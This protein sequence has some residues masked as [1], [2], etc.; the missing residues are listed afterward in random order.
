MN[1]YLALTLGLACAGLGGELFVRGAVGL[2]RL[3]RIPAGIVGATVAAFA[4]SS[5]ELSVSVT[6]ALAG[7]PQIA[8]GDALGSNV[9]NTALILGLALA[10]SGLQSQRSNLWR[11]FPVAT[12]A[13]AATAV[14]LLDGVLSRLDGALMLA[15][16]L[17][18]LG[19]AVL[20]AIRHR[21]RATQAAVGERTWPT[22]LYG[23]AGLVLL[24]A[25]GHFVVLGARAIAVTFGIS[26]FVIGATLVAIGTSM[27]EL[28][29]T[30]VARLRGHDDVGLGAVLGSNIVN[31]LFIVAI[32]ALIRPI[33]VP[34]RSVASTLSFGALAVLCAFPPRSGFI[35]RRRGMLLLVLYLVNL[36]AVLG[37]IDP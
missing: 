25:G 5:P 27:P 1:E 20:E 12:L 18:W 17:A 11:D 35:K 23:A 31:G 26:D 19:A 14:L 24:V 32:A 34:L 36:A 4:T 6:S 22:F 3:A 7:E 2:A 30:I 21:H 37:A 10:T 13:P 16:F 15:L 29:T 33:D 28:A 9:V 8:L